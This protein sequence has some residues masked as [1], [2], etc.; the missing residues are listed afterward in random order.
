MEIEFVRT[1][2]FWLGFLGGNGVGGLFAYLVKKE[3]DKRYEN[4]SNEKGY[5]DAL[6]KKKKIIH[7]V[8]G[9]IDEFEFKNENLGLI[10]DENGVP[11]KEEKIEDIYVEYF[12][13]IFEKLSKDKIYLQEDTLN[14]LESLRTSY[15]NYIAGKN[16]I[17]DNHQNDYEIT[18]AIEKLNKEFLEE[19]SYEFNILL[20]NIK[21]NERRD[22]QEKLGI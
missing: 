5:Q 19:T 14:K 18:H 7:E 1:T 16:T 15:V 6:E 8:M 13:K 4:K 10:D 21:Y 22:I 17:I 12:V 2:E 11:I 3:I 9:M 20:E